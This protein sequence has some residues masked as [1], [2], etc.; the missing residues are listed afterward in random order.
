[1][2]AFFS[3]VAGLVFG[4]G[5]IVSRMVDPAKVLGFLDLAGRWDPSLALVMGGAATVGLAGFAIAQRR[6]RT[7]LGQPMRLPV[8]RRVDVRLVAGSAA[9]GVGWGLVGFCPGPAITAAGAG[10][11]KAIVFVLAMLAGMGLYEFLER[12]RLAPE[13]TL[14]R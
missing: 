11:P 4:L 14:A 7:L 3:L 13:A 5:L 10:D 9:F 12:R 6:A 8:T 1:M 2:N